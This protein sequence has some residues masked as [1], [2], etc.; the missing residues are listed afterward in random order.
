MTLKEARQSIDQIARGPETIAAAVHGVNAAA[1]RYKPSPE[2][3]C[4]LQIV[5]HL[6]DVEIVLG[7]RLRQAL[8]EAQ[9]TFAVMDQDAWADNLGYM[10]AS[11][12]DSLEAYRV[13]RKANLRLLR[14]IAE[15]DLGKGGFHPELKRSLTVAEIIQRLAAHDPNHLGQIERLKQQAKC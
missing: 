9:P 6:A 5:A 1:L 3:W 8:A 4:I 7:H 11:F 15:A 13:A 12:E 10:E 2:K 14:R